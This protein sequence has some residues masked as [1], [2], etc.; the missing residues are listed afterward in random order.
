MI[1]ATDE[2]ATGA[3]PI[4]RDRMHA[5]YAHATRLEY[6]FWEGAYRDVSWPL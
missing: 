1:A 2:A 3:S 5:A 4:L 6:G